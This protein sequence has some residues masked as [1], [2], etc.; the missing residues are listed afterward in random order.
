MNLQRTNDKYLVSIVVAT[1]N[2]SKYAIPCITSLLEIPS[3]ELQIVVHDT[4][5]RDAE[6]QLWIENRN[7]ARLVYRHC[8][9]RL[10][11]TENH[12]RALA[13]AEGRYV[14]MIGDDDSVSKYIIEVAEY[15]QE[16]HIEIFTPT[17][18]ASYLWPDFK[19]KLYGAAHAGRLYLKTFSGRIERT[20]TSTSLKQALIDACQGTDRLPKLYHGLVQRTLLDQLRHDHGKVFHGVSPDISAS[21]GLCLAER[22]YHKLDLPVI[23]P[24]S[25][26][27]SNA[28]RSAL[29]A[30]KGNIENDPHMLPFKNLVWPTS[31]PRFFSV[32]TVWAQAA[33]ETLRCAGS[34]GQLK[35]FNLPRL[36]ALCL[37]NHLDCRHEVYQAF[38]SA[39]R[40]GSAHFT[41][42]D[43]SIEMAKLI[44]SGL[45]RKSKRLM[46]PGPAN[47]NEILTIVDD[48]NKAQ[49]ALDIRLAHFFP[50]G[51]S[52]T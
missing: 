8:K 24:G 20:T 28:G 42:G 39:K 41:W 2:R 47:G 25:S 17:T 29:R 49:K 45:L 44:G 30:H 40:E 33:W 3:D 48:V 26:G 15:A 36:Y 43:V 10:S 46:N 50:L 13:L 38:S 7:D 4:S 37:S 22:P 12:E 34:T 5:D 6:L 23:L 18:K 9:E 52:V 51:S 19:T 32:E 27:G 1:H 31:I 21:I 35:S 11:M 14:C 16:H